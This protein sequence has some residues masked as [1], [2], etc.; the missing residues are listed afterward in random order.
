MRKAVLINTLGILAAVLL[1]YG[2]ELKSSVSGASSGELQTTGTNQRDN[3][4]NPGLNNPWAPSS[5]APLHLE[6]GPFSV[7]SY[8]GKCLSYS[9]AVPAVPLD[10]IGVVPGE[11]GRDPL[12][13]FTDGML[14]ARDVPIAAA[15]P[16][17]TVYMYDCHTGRRRPRWGSQEIIVEE[18]NQDHEVLLH[19]GSKVI[20]VTGNF[21]VNRAPLELQDRAQSSEGAKAQTFALDGDSIIL[22]ADRNLVVKVQNARGANLTPVVLA[23]REL[24]DAEFWTF[25]TLDG[26]DQKPT[27]GFVRV[28]QDEPDIYKAVDQAE[29][30]RVIEIS[31]GTTIMLDR[32]LTIMND[33]VTMRGGRHGTIPG[34]VLKVCQET[35]PA[36]SFDQFPE[37]KAVIINSVS[38][39]RVTGL[40]LIGPS[41]SQGAHSDMWGLTA[42]DP[43]QPHELFSD[44]IKHNIY[45]D[46]NELTGWS[47]GAVHVVNSGHAS[48]ESW[49]CAS[50]Y[51]R[52]YPNVHV[53]NNFMHDNQTEAGGYGVSV[54]GDGYAEILGNTFTANK[55]AIAADGTA[56][57]GYSGWYNLVTSFAPCFDRGWIYCGEEQDFDVH[58]SDSS[59]HHTGGIGGGHVEIARNTF[60][61]NSHWSFE[62]RGVSCAGPGGVRF[63]DNVDVH[64]EADDS[65]QWYVH[66]PICNPQDSQCLQW[67][68]NELLNPGGAVASRLA[69]RS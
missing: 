20:G 41:Q 51:D 42:R 45:I 23:E 7:R 8:L 59:T 39:V 17:P 2:Y 37:K 55:H 26:S 15:N 18:V 25:R 43:S 24:N 68:R 27:S 34:A 19:A 32:P 5:S 35:D 66:A 6:H 14:M 57:S 46:H 36:C 60:L 3:S 56:S 12:P 58:G 30:N 1:T 67:C 64:H 52:P 50:F 28:P 54:G 40:Q 38:Y 10:D 21:L 16:S 53:V 65:V 63:V 11:A 4:S 33:E 29:K 47:G 9:I 61:A 22:A 13:L 69:V 62:I 49:N 44:T 48:T 31:P